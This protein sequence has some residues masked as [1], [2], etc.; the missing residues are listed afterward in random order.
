MSYLSDY[1]FVNIPPGK[2]KYNTVITFTETDR[3]NLKL[4]SNAFMYPEMNDQYASEAKQFVDE[5]ST[6]RILIWV[7]FLM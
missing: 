7:I 3:S 2:K 4:E 6:G 5:I 1:T